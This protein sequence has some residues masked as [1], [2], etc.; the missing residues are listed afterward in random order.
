MCY[1]VDQS[2]SSGKAE[3]SALDEAIEDHLCLR[4]KISLG[5]QIAV[6]ETFI[7]ELINRIMNDTL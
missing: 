2:K 4:S 6:D 5:Y 1:T 3:R 7:E